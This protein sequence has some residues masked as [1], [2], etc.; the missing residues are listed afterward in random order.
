MQKSFRLGPKAGPRRCLK[1]KA[2]ESAEASGKQLRERA[3]DALLHAEN[4][5]RETDMEMH[6]LPNSSG[7]K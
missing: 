6:I 1:T 2:P 3:R 7:C 4:A 5:E